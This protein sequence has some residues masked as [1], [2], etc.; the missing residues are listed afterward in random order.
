M[1]TGNKFGTFSGVFLPSVL[2][3]LGA[4][5]FYIAPQVVGGVPEVEADVG[6]RLHGVLGGGEGGA[7]AAGGTL[8]GQV[9]H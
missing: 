8:K 6:H 2:A 9:L 1:G 3:I 4:V 5:M 7:V